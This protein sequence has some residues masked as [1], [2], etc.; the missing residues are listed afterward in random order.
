MDLFKQAFSSITDPVDLLEYYY[1][2]FL[3]QQG[4]KEEGLKYL[5][6]AFEKGEPE[7]I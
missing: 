1:A 5:K 6:I 2:N 3:I 4:E 7:A